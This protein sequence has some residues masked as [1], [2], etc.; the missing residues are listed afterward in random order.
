MGQ[1]SGRVFFQGNVRFEEQGE[2]VPGKSEWG[3]DTL[4]RKFRGA[5]FLLAAYI[6]TL[7][8]GA[9]F[10][11]FYLQTWGADDDPTFPVVT[12]NY[13]G[14][15]NGIPD[16][17]PVNDTVELSGS[18]STDTPEKASRDFSYTADQT[19]WK[20]ISVG[21]TGSRFSEV[22]GGDPIIRQSIITDKDGKRYPGNAP[23]GLVTALTVGVGNEL[24]SHREERI[25]GTP[26]YE[27]EDV[28]QRRFIIP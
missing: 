26:W 12:L 5:A 9:A 16:P 1:F 25:I 8:Q 20:Y 4:T 3:V 21:R 2:P 23:V 27:N 11:G 15:L 6:A 24:V 22:Q 17:H 18:V 7:R 13:K 14:L 28:V 10:N 19:S